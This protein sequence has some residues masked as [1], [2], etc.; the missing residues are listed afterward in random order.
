MSVSIKVY[1]TDLPNLT[2]NHVKY[3]FIDYYDLRVTDGD[4][5]F[6]EDLES[7]KMGMYKEDVNNENKTW[8]SIVLKRSIFESDDKIRRN[9]LKEYILEDIEQYP[10][11][12]YIVFQRF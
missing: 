6:Y 1:L 5:E 12:D 4:F 11:L 2:L 8:D 7:N 9:R 10:D 3:Q